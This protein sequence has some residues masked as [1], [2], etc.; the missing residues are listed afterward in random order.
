[1]AVPLVVFKDASRRQ[2]YLQLCSNYGYLL[3]AL[4]R[5]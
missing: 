4:P 1:M 2:E 3:S 5:L